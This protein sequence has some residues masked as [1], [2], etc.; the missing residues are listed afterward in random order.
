[1]TTKA[2]TTGT[3]WLDERW[4]GGRIY[5]NRRS[6]LGKVYV[7][8]RSHGGRRYSVPLTNCNEKQAE[9][10]LALFL[11]DP[12]AYAEARRSKRA[13]PAESLRIDEETAQ[14]V[15]DALKAEGKTEPYLKQ[16]A[17]YVTDW[18][19]EFEGQAIA[20]IRPEQVE[21][22]LSKRGARNHR[23]SA[24]KSFCTFFESRAGGELLKH[25]QN[26]VAKIEIKKPAATKLKPKKDYAMSVVEKHYRHVDVQSARDL[27]VL[28]A[29]GGLHGTE[30][31]RIA[32]GDCELK[33]V[34]GQGTAIV[35]TVTFVHKGR[36][37][38][39]LSLDRQMFEAARRL[40]ALEWAPAKNTIGKTMRRAAKAIEEKNADGKRVAHLLPGNLRHSFITWA[41]TMG[42]KVSVTGAGMPLHEIQQIV[43]H[44][45]GSKI[46]G[47]VYLNEEVPPMIALPIKLEHPDDPPLSSDAQLASVH[48]LPAAG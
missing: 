34:D 46:T 37:E 45:T 22:I 5:I 42:R 30:I 28:R 16:L 7:I 36:H 27:L 11:R 33:E 43:G 15:I 1:M 35:G 19:N 41:K 13:A 47:D 3:Q 26:P 20:T 40:I 25:E 44:R 17:A 8:E 10:E 31:E 23:L 21:K 4:L 29:K 18:G 14:K 39:R 32:A 9:A 38:H 24:L 12:P 2:K 6:G 48:P